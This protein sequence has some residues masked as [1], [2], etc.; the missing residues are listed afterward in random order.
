MV[1]DDSVEPPPMLASRTCTKIWAIMDSEK[2]ED[3]TPNSGTFLDSAFFS[4]E[5]VLPASYLLG[6]SE[7]EEIKSETPRA[8]R[9]IE[10]IEESPRRSSHWIGFIASI[11]VGMVI[12]FVLF[13]VIALLTRSTQS[14][15]ADSW[16][17]EIA[18]RVGNYEQIHANQWSTLQNE[19]LLPYNLATSSWQELHSEVFWHRHNVLS[20]E[21]RKSWL[22]DPDPPTIKEVFATIIVQLPPLSQVSLS[23][24]PLPLYSEASSP[25]ASDMSAMADSMLLVVPGQENTVRSAF[26]QNILLRDGRVFF[27]IL[28][29]AESPKR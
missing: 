4:P 1:S 13:P 25:V 18:R 16:E 3:Y 5:T 24:S 21:G 19:E 23:E 10:I 8:S 6:T 14:Y 11:S 17:S 7:P 26:G 20:R 15:V 29:G 9:R 22:P 2:Q 12:A 28:P 27:R